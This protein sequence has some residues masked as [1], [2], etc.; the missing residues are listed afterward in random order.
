[1]LRLITLASSLAF[2]AVPALASS[3]GYD[4]APFTSI[5]ASNGVVLRVAVGGEQQITASA[6]NPAA[7]PSS[8]SPSLMVS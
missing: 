6:G 4:V 7:W 1:M 5:K 3:I 2:L 8:S